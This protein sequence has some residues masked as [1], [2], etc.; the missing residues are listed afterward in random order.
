MD[1]DLLLKQHPVFYW[2]QPRCCIT[3]SSMTCFSFCGTEL[4]IQD[5]ESWAQRQSH[6]VSRLLSAQPHEDGTVE[7][8]RLCVFH[9]EPCFNLSLSPLSSSCL[10]EII[11]GSPAA[12]GRAALLSQG[13]QLQRRPI[14]RGDNLD[15]LI[16]ASEQMCG[17]R[18]TLWETDF[19]WGL[20]TF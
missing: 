1:F 14:P 3:T 15:P 8:A 18:A 10:L 6:T 4:T 17:D 7:C 20:K 13:L 16:P 9:A 19:L 11:S 2:L 12:L 5:F